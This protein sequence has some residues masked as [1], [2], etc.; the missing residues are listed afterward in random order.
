[1]SP[2]LLLLALAAPTSAPLS[3]D[4]MP[5]C[6][7]ADRYPV[8]SVALPEGTDV[9]A[10][11]LR[12]RTDDDWFGIS[13]KIR[14]GRAAAVLPR[15]K[16]SLREFHYDIST[17]DQ[18]GGEARTAE[19]TAIVARAGQACAAGVIAS[20]LDAPTDTLIVE[21]P[22]VSRHGKTTHSRLVPPGFSPKGVAGDIGMF[23]MS[24]PMAIAGGVVLTG[25]LATAAALSGDPK[26]VVST[27]PPQVTASVVLV[28]SNP[29]P[30]GTLSVGTPV[31]LSFNITPT[32]VVQPGFLRVLLL[33]A[34]RTC[35]ELGANTPALAPQQT[36]TVVATSPPV[37]PGGALT[38]CTAG[39]RL[40]TV[41]FLW[42]ALARAQPVLLTPS[43]I[44]IDYTLQ[45]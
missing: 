15:P 42:N 34:N 24:A 5:R 21:A 14:D 10:A 7:T 31:T 33:G 18:G 17:V 41:T 4:A 35:L 45:P 6:V 22:S 32:D 38:T 29:P 44:P 27:P 43:Q 40:G 8:I 3:L 28:G 26:P 1:M 11:R 12:F 30:G 19:Q 20:A 39:T 13:M 16:G 37:V 25:G 23:D 9:T 2:L 36:T